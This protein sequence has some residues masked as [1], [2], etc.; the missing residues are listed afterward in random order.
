MTL[1]SIKLRRYKE[2]ISYF[3]D[4]VSL[5]FVSNKEYYQAIKEILNYRIKHKYNLKHQKYNDKIE[6][7]ISDENIFKDLFIP[8]C[9]KC[10]DCKLT[11]DCL[12]KGMY[13]L[14]DCINQASQNIRQKI[15]EVYE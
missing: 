13:K 3:N 8:L 1:I 4:F 14:Q 15:L 9:P 10:S 2:A 11:N 6:A 7:D 12:T 5:D